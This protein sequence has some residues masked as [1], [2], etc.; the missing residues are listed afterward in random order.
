MINQIG[1]T[2]F[3][4]KTGLTNRNRTAVQHTGNG[5][6]ATDRVSV[7]Y[8]YNSYA[9]YNVKG[10]LTVNQNSGYYHLE[11]FVSSMLA[12]QNMAIKD[13]LDGTP[14]EIDPATQEEAGA[15]VA[16][17]GYWGVDQT[18][19]RIFQFAVNASGNDNEKLE[20]VKAAIDKGFNMALESFGGSL[21][22]ISY[23]TFDAVMEKLDVWAGDD[24]EE[25]AE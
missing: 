21:P 7:N 15:L 1:T 25:T 3:P 17:D 13:A 24:G 19:D 12:E 18:S 10:T 14:Y 23:Q 5:K 22:E 16:D 20:E 8:E 2:N 9:A 11:S 6:A 4:D